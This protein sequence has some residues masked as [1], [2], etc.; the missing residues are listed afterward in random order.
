MITIASRGAATQLRRQT[1]PAAEG[2]ASQLTRS[3][4]VRRRFTAPP[5][6][7]SR[8]STSTTSGGTECASCAGAGLWKAEGVAD[9]IAVS[10]TKKHNYIQ[11]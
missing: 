4:K 11:N 1:G 7:I 8:A 5:P 9:A 3:T 2:A 10:T 6:R